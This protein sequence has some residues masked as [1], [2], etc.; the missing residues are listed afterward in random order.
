MGDSEK[1]M[2]S[3]EFY[4]RGQDHISRHRGEASGIILTRDQVAEYFGN[5]VFDEI[6]NYGSAI[7]PS[8]HEEPSRTLREARESLG[9]TT[10]DLA[11]AINLDKSL[12]EKAEDQNRRSNIRDIAKISQFLG[13]KDDIAIGTTSAIRDHSLGARLKSAKNATGSIYTA[14]I[15]TKLSEAGWIIS[16]QI[17]LMRKLGDEKKIPSAFSPDPNYGSHDEPTHVHAYR[18]AARTREILGITRHKPIDSIRKILEDSLGIPVVWSELGSKIAGATV[19]SHGCRGIVLNNKFRDGDVNT[20]RFTMAHELAHLLWDGDDFLE[21]LVVDSFE[22]L[23]KLTST[24]KPSKKHHFVEVRAN[25]F[26]AEFLAPRDA[27]FPIYS[28]H[29]RKTK[30]GILAVMNEFGVGYHC[31]KHQIENHMQGKIDDEK[32]LDDEI[33]PDRLWAASENGSYATDLANIKLSR[34]SRFSDV[35]V[36]SLLKNIITD[37]LASIYLDCTADDL[38]KVTRILGETSL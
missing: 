18:L 8:S 13:I 33:D 29:Q 14:N 28:D 25:A 26:A 37:N 12:V 23:K 31:A 20:F 1:T 38:K 36:K 3:Q 15:V 4:T 30:N 5:R 9:L 27:V 34:G 17:S 6:E 16:T 24:T 22:S 2:S 19:S 11:K 21:N 7:I 32:I 35:V 10:S